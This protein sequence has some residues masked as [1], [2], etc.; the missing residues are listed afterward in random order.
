[1]NKINLNNYEAYL[2]DFMEGNLSKQDSVELE[3]FLKAHPEIET[4]IFDISETRLKP[5]RK[6]GFDKKMELKRNEE[7]PELKQKDA[8]LI[9]LIEGDLNDKEKAEAENLINTNEKA[10]KDFKHY[11]NTR[12]KADKSKTYKDKESLKKKAP[13]ISLKAVRYISAAAVLTGLM[14]FAFIKLNTN[15]FKNTPDD[16]AQAGINLEMKRESNHEY[17]I[18]TI[19]TAYNKKTKN[20]SKSIDEQ[21]NEAMINT[22]MINRM[23]KKNAHHIAQ[24]SENQKIDITET[25]KVSELE[26]ATPYSSLT[27]II[28]KD[29]KNKKFNIPNRE[30][31]NNKLEEYSP[32]KK[33]REAKNDFL[34]TNSDKLLKKV[35][36]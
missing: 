8:L 10:A 36:N 25:R 7:M 22:D 14:L 31:I 33:L 30:D 4:E 34:A 9:G 11:L 26:P 20:E 35:K 16:I 13:L 28:E 19:N 12:L 24:N 6:I 3:S 5:N 23:P 1:M 32:I 27:L 2:L 15:D 29:K 18:K 21:V 17:R